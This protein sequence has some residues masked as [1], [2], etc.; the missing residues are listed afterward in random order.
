MSRRM[1]VGLRTLILAIYDEASLTAAAKGL[2]GT[3]AQLAALRET[4]SLASGPAGRPVDEEEVMGLVLDARRTGRLRGH[5]HAAMA[6]ETASATPPMRVRRLRRA[7]PP[8]LRSA[9]RRLAP[10]VR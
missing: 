3:L 9:T 5:G 7:V 8:G 2:K 1:E 10:V 6:A 4:V